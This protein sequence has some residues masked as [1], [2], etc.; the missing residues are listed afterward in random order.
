MNQSGLTLDQIAQ[1][2]NQGF[3]SPINILSEKEVIDIK[4]EINF[5]EEKWP[6]QINGLNRNNIHYFSPI[7]DKLVHNN[8]ILDVIEDIIG[9]NILVAGT[10][11][12]LKEPQN[13]GFVSWH[14]DGKYQGWEPLNFLTA[15]LA[16]TDV[17]EEN[18][19]MR[20]WPGSHKNN[21]KP[22]KDTY[23]ENNL[24][25]RGQT[26][27][28]VPFKETVPIILKAG[29]LSI[30]HPKTV[31]GSGPN[32]SKKRRIGFAVQSYIGTNVKQKIG[33]AYV[34]QARGNDIYKYHKHTIRP[35][36]RMNKKD[37]LIRDIANKELQ[38]ILYKDASKIGKF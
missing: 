18:G 28:N 3:F 33:K 14:Q 2:N 7:F 25:T 27:E 8:K 23:D 10:C 30:H 1:Y 4:A 6:E 35:K 19:C 9:S 36:E 38:K 32:L 21:F 37:I 16:V 11:L 26:I 29:Q 17:T 13:K 12:F 24:L 31:H 20:M 5:I 22:H 34:Q 15:W